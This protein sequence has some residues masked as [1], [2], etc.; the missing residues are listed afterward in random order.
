MAA[1]LLVGLVLVGWFTSAGLGYDGDG[2]GD[3]SPTAEL[4]A[5]ALGSL[6]RAKRWPITFNLDYTVVSDYVWRGFN[7]SEF[8]GEGREKV[9]HQLGA[10]VSVDLDQ[11]GSVGFAWWG[12]FYTDQKSLGFDPSGTADTH[13]QEADY[14]LNW[15]YEFKNIGVGMELG[16]IAYE[17]PNVSGDGYSTYE[18]YASLS[19]NDGKWF[20]LEDGVLNPYVAYYL[21]I[22]LVEGGWFELGISH[23]FS[24]SEDK[25]LLKDLTLTPSLVLGVDNRYWDKA[26]G[27]THRSTKLAVLL[28][29]LELGYDLSGALG[30]PA[31]Y[32]SVSLTA[33]VNFS[34]ALREDLLND[35]LYGGM[36]L[37]YEW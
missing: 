20:G 25:P 24:L 28:W 36:T 33:F 8:K 35:E 23:E 4:E 26:L 30:I 37:A 16:W 31:E 9:N 29:G 10:A 15:S 1:K 19:F 5:E 22:D 13:L 11:F 14:T 34:D 32:G 7:L 12:E 27:T 2:G 18:I 17:F 3:Y 6:G 21:D